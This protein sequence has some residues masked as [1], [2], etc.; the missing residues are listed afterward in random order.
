MN[1]R[2]FVKCIPCL[3]YK[4]GRTFKNVPVSVWP[5]HV[6]SS[7]FLATPEA[8]RK[9]E[10]A[11]AHLLANIFLPTAI[12]EMLVGKNSEKPLVV[13]SHTYESNALSKTYCTSLPTKKSKSK[14]ILTLFKA[15]FLWLYGLVFFPIEIGDRAFMKWNLMPNTWKSFYWS[16]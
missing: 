4:K 3:I 2:I 7:A 1:R 10:N 5:Y 14:L 12:L 13:N 6:Y 15:S 9:S 8:G 11:D 16:L